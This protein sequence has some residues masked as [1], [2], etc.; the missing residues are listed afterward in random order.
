M[1]RKRRQGKVYEQYQICRRDL[2]T[3][4]PAIQ[5]A[6]ADN[7]PGTV[8]LNLITFNHK[9]LGRRRVRIGHLLEQLFAAA[10]M[11]LAQTQPVTGNAE[12]TREEHTS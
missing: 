1:Q 7:E 9:L 6:M 11:E 8:W 12:P 10:L 4:L 2:L 3:V 5:H